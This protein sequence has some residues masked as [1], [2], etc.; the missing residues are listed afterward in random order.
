MVRVYLR[1]ITGPVWI[2]TFRRERLLRA[3]F[4]DER[5]ESNE[6]CNNDNEENA[7]GEETALSFAY[8]L[9]LDS[10]FSR[11]INEAVRFAICGVHF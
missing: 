3:L 10:R 11:A 8:L 9:F 6:R 4:P 1:L 7:E 5:I 2:R